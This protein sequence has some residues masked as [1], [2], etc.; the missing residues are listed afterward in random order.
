MCWAELIDDCIDTNTR[1][2]TR[3]MVIRRV[4]TFA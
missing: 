4:R 1:Q 3:K 2:T